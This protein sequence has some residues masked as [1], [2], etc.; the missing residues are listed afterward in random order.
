MCRASTGMG[1]YL[2]PEK[3]GWVD[4]GISNGSV[5]FMRYPSGDYNIVVKS[6]GYTFSARVTAQGSSRCTAWTT[7]SQPSWSSTRST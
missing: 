5:T 7:T 2:E 4:D 6:V 3:D 1:F